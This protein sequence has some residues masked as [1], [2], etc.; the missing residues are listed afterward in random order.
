MHHPRTP[1]RYTEND[2]CSLP[3]VPHNGIR[4]ERTDATSTVDGD[5]RSLPPQGVCRGVKPT[6]R[7]ESVLSALRSSLSPHFPESEARNGRKFPQHA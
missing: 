6:V 1:G 2:E 3:G 4:I 7:V 5:L